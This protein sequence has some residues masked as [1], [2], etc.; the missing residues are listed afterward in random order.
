MNFC[1]A[2]IRVLFWYVYFSSIE[3]LSL[4]LIFFLNL[5]SHPAGV[6][7]EMVKL[8]VCMCDCILEG[9]KTSG[10]VDAAGLFARARDWTWP[11]WNQSCLTKC[12]WGLWRI[13][14][15]MSLRGRRRVPWIRMNTMSSPGCW[16]EVWC[17]R[18][19]GVMAGMFT[20]DNLFLY[21]SRGLQQS[22]AIAIMWD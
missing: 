5:I 11:Q 16:E 7:R 18:A 2:K 8:C 22:T 14:S 4:I 21:C 10:E 19:S 15:W 17:G 12:H 3:Q 20:W 6:G 13:Y 1:S 9:R